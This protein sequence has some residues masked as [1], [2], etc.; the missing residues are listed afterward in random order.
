MKKRNILMIIAIILMILPYF[1]NYYTFLRILS[2]IFGFAL[3]SII[4]FNYKN[5]ILNI[6]IILTIFISSYFIDYILCYKQRIPIMAKEVV[7]SKKVTTYYS[8]LYQV[9]ICNNNWNVDKF[10]NQGFNC[11]EDSLNE[12][13]V[14]DFLNVYESDKNKYLKIKGKVSQI[15]G[16]KYIELEPYENE[17]TEQNGNVV[18]K[19][20]IIL[21]LPIKDLNIDLKKYKIYDEVQFI[22]RVSKK[23]KEDDI[24]IYLFTDVIIYE[25]DLYDNFEIVVENDNK[26][27]FD[28]TEYLKINDITYYTSCLK[29]IDVKFNEENI[30]DLDYVLFD[31]KISLDTLINLSTKNSKDSYN[32][33]LYEL[34]NLKV[35]VCNNSNEVI[36]GTNIQLED[37]YCN[38]EDDRSV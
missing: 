14:N 18:F 20:D 7:S 3:L 31:E 35:L 2:Y 26:C 13:S 36:L 9:N 25:S 5:I 1:I 29:N 30:Y 6:I 28:K 34:N 22:G 37:G 24:N 12:I 10:Y 32:N 33:T 38:V 19:K 16:E 27:K 23:I 21:R 15:I 17:Q 4:I 11:D 8:L